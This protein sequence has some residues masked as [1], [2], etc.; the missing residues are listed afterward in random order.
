MAFRCCSVGAACL[1]RRPR[2]GR[3]HALRVA[4]LAL[5]GRVHGVF[6][7]RDIPPRLV[8]FVNFLSSDWAQP[9]IEFA[10]FVRWD[11]SDDK[12]S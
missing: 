3:V 7:G 1:R 12:S 4:G 2:Q 10:P 8:A 6:G 11:E 5:R 9:S